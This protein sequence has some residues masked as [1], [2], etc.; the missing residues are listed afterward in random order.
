MTTTF[1]TKEFLSRG[2]GGRGQGV[3]LAGLKIFELRSFL[4]KTIVRHSK[5][6]EFDKGS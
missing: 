1:A 4:S 3:S 2:A 6:R 5:M